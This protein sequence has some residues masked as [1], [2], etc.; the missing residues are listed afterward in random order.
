MV[1]CLNCTLLD[2]SH[3]ML[4]NTQLP[5]SYWLKAL[6][7]ATFLH[8]VSS[9]CSVTT[10]PTEAYTGMKPN[11]LWLQVFGCIA[12]S[13]QAKTEHSSHLLGITTTTFNTD[14]GS[15]VSAIHLAQNHL[16]CSP[17]KHITHP[18]FQAIS[19][20]SHHQPQA[21]CRPIPLS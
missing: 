18:L 21:S 15:I 20:P 16:N 9:S 12:H 2:K 13:N 6:N 19:Y 17:T 5:K 4:T 11:V 10:T 7:Y 3:T 1:E 14:L 8:N